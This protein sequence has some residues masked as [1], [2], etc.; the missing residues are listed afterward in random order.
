MT[1]I[2]ERLRGALKT[3]PYTTLKRAPDKF[4]VSQPDIEK[5]ADT[6][7]KL[8]K[9]LKRIDHASDHYSHDFDYSEDTL[10]Y[11]HKSSRNIAREALKAV[12]GD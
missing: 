2:Q 11:A 3:M 5:A 9:A 8:V 4:L 10:R 6:I 7:D 1:T 12:R